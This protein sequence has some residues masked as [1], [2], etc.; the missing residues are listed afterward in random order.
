MSREGWI[1][2]K[3]GAYKAKFLTPTSLGKTTKQ[4]QDLHS[5]HCSQRFNV[6]LAKKNLLL[7]P[8]YNV[9]ATV[10]VQVS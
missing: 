7:L 2:E 9:T 8:Q 6:T 5:F 3:S 10:E 4:E 1:D